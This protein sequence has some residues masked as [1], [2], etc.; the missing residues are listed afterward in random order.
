M[1][2]YMLVVLIKNNLD[3]IQF[4][5]VMRLI[6]LIIGA[7]FVAL[8]IFLTMHANKWSGRVISL[9]DPDWAKENM[10][11]VASVSEHSPSMWVNYWQDMSV[12][13]LFVPL[14]FYYTLVHK[15]THGK[16]FIAMYG[17]FCVYFSCAMIRLMLVLAPAVCVLAGIGVSHV[18]SSALKAIRLAF[19][20]YSAPD[21]SKASDLKGWKA[22]ANKK[23]KQRMPFEVSVILLLFIFSILKTYVFHQMDLAH[24]YSSP[25][26]IMEWGNVKDGNRVIIDDFREAYYWLKQNTKKE[27][28]ILAWWDYGYQLA[29]MSNRTVIVDNNTW[30]NTH[31][32]TVGKILASD[33]K[34]GYEMAKSLD[35]DYVMVVFGGKAHYEGDDLAKFLWFVRIAN[36]AF[37]GMDE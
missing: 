2:A 12:M 8:I 36:S 19:T 14:G 10:P 28:K 15:L 1:N 27:A 3:E 26:F 33:E 24:S 29:G 25:S 20:G 35:A 37:P 21:E 7:M 13:L 30:N 4:V 32:A 22:K 17:V 34:E 16:L 23:N 5:A 18:T 11:L 6:T 31:I 9:I